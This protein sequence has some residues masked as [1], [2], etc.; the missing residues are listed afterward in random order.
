M[1]RENS[2]CVWL[3]RSDILRICD[4]GNMCDD[5][6]LVAYDVIKDNIILEY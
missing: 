1:K 6:M 4:N 2:I 3:L 5:N